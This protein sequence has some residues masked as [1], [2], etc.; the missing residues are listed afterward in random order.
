MS[1]PVAARERHAPT[2]YLTVL[3]GGQGGT[4]P[5]ASDQDGA[6]ESDPMHSILQM[7]KPRPREEVGLP[8][9]IK[10]AG[11]KIELEV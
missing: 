2:W 4:G 1:A 5:R 3:L 7:R 6:S 8:K 10:P 11:A 9:A